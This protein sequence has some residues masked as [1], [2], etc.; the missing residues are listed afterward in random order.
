VLSP[1]RLK[2]ASTWAPWPRNTI[3]CIQNDFWAYGMFGANDAPIL[4]Q[5]N[6]VSKQI[7]ARF[8]MTQSPKS[9]IGC[10]QNDFW[11]LWYVR[12]KLCTYRASSMHYLRIDSNKLPLEP[13]HLGVPLGASKMIFD[14]MVHWSKP[15]NFL[16][17]TLKQSSNRLK[18]ASSWASSPSGTIGCIQNDF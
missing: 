18:R 6:T 4:H 14:P 2:W 11:D 9:S 3:G 1:N 17:P 8:L 5:H 15:C 10:V 13:H 12:R 16:A 7:E